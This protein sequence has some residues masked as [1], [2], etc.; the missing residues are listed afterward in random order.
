MGHS[1]KN[2]EQTLPQVIC[3]GLFYPSCDGPT[4]GTSDVTRKRLVSY[5]LFG[6]RQLW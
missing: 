3:D 1:Y 4:L 6:T 2:G 5:G